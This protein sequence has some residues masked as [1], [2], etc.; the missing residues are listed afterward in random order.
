MGDVR[1]FDNGDMRLL[2]T[3]ATHAGIALQNSRLIDQLR[4][5]SLHDALTGLPNRVLLRND[6]VDELWRSA[7]SSRAAARS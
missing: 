6:I 2:E 5:E 3:V 7:E 1:T 4:H